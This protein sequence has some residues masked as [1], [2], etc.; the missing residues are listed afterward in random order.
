MISC[1]YDWLPKWPPK[2]TAAWTCARPMPAASSRPP[3]WVEGPKHLDHPLLLLQLFQKGADQKWVARVWTGVCVG[4]QHC[5]QQLCPQS[6]NSCSSGQF[7]TRVPQTEKVNIFE[8]A[9]LKILSFFSAL[10]ITV[11]VRWVRHRETV[12]PHL[13]ASLRIYTGVFCFIILWLFERQRC[14][15]VGSLVNCL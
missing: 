3:T 11:I 1:I 15:D 9:K 2:A 13:C 14:R 4:Y 5:R 12:I 7:N 8:K 10:F 6:H